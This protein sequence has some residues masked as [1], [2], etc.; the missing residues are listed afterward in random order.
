MAALNGLMAGLPWVGQENAHGA[1][2]KRHTPS[3]QLVHFVCGIRLSGFAA[4][5]MNVRANRTVKGMS[6]ASGKQILA[7]V[8]LLSA[9]APITHTSIRCRLVDVGKIVLEKALAGWWARAFVVTRVAAGGRGSGAPLLLRL[10]WTLPAHPSGKASP[11]VFD[12][13]PQYGL[14]VKG[15][16]GN[17]S[18]RNREIPAAARPFDGPSSSGANAEKEGGYSNGAVCAL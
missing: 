16:K 4:R 18:Y 15:S 6:A 17:T 7:S 8:R 10:T 5:G 1:L 9:L 11:R 13:G 3:G 12:G 14:V 2:S